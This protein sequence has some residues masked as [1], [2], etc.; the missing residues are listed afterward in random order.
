MGALELGQVFPRREQEPQNANCCK[1]GR[2]CTLRGHWGAW[3]ERK[4]LRKN[5]LANMEVSRM[6]SKAWSLGK[7]P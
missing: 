6:K 1:P 5:L 4:K 7:R 2:G 3:K